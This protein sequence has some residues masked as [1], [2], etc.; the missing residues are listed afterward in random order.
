MFSIQLLHARAHSSNTSWKLPCFGLK[1]LGIFS[2]L[3][4]IL[5]L[6]DGRNPKANHLRCVN[7]PWIM[8]DSPYQL[9]SLPDFWTINSTKLLQLPLGF[10]FGHLGHH[11]STRPVPQPLAAVPTGP[12]G[13]GAIYHETP[14]THGKLRVLATKKVKLIPITRSP[15]VFLDAR[16]SKWLLGGLGPGGLDSYRIPLWKRLLLK[17]P[18]WRPP[19]P[20]CLEVF[21]WMMRPLES[22][23]LSDPRGP[24]KKNPSFQSRHLATSEGYGVV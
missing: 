8:V 23:S 17:I 6:S 2:Q 20:T 3:E 24:P 21:I 15:S 1:F 5:L 4:T 12:V 9:V 10:S 16:F 22:Q 19:K 18:K 11:T 7:S 14:T 13:P